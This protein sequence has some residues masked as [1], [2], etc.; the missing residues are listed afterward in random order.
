MNQS[1]TVTVHCRSTHQ[2]CLIHSEWSIYFYLETGDVNFTLKGTRS[3]NRRGYVLTEVW[4]RKKFSLFFTYTHHALI[5]WNEHRL[6]PTSNF[7]QCFWNAV[8]ENKMN[9]SQNKKA[10]FMWKKSALFLGWIQIYSDFF[11]SSSLFALLDYHT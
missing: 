10:G 11:S 1:V 5:F 3:E 7:F 9:T 4:Q 2:F 6:C 8:E